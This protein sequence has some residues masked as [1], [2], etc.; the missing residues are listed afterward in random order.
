MFTY[1]FP[2][3]FIYM[4]TYNF[5]YRDYLVMHLCKGSFC[6]STHSLPWKLATL[7]FTLATSQ[8]PDSQV[9]YN[10]HNPNL[11]FPSQIKHHTQSH[12]LAYQPQPSSAPKPSFSHSSEYLL[13]FSHKFLVLPMS[14]E[15]LIKL[16]PSISFFCRYFA[17]VSQQ[18][19]K[20]TYE[21]DRKDA[22][23]Q[24]PQKMCFSCFPPGTFE[25]VWRDI[26]KKRY[27]SIFF[28]QSLPG[29]ANLLPSSFFQR[30]DGTCVS[31]L[32]LL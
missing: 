16:V 23:L 26:D 1:I 7:L 2:C 5:I 28:M 22:S 20:P 17:Y 12:V 8:I 11:F 30:S 4:S 31:F 14:C 29:K 19:D 24:F 27:H 9:V 15:I 25:A 10:I 6:N 21:Q 32:L 3:M 13:N 18:I